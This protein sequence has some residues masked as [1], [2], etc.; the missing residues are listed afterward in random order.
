MG[1]SKIPI[2]NFYRILIIHM[3]MT[4]SFGFAQDKEIQSPNESNWH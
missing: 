2:S 1:K 4:K 3:Q